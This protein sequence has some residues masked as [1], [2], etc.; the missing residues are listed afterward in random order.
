[1]DIEHIAVDSTTLF[2]SYG[3]VTAERILER[4]GVKVPHD[5]LTKAIHKQSSFYY[6]LLK[7]PLKNVM[8]GIILQQAS[9]YYV[10][11]QKLFIDYLLSPEAAKGPEAQGAQTREELEDE[12][13]KLEVM[14]EA[15][16]RVMLDHNNFISMTQNI[17]ITVTEDWKTVHE[18]LLN[19]LKSASAKLSINARTDVLELCISKICSLCD[20]KAAR[21][22]QTGELHQILTSTLENEKAEGLLSSFDG[23]LQFM[24]NF[25]ECIE[26][27]NQQADE[28]NKLACSHRT[29]FYDV[30]LRVLDLLRL[31]P[32]YK[33]DPEK[34]Q[35]NKESLYFDKTIGEHE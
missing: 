32:E 35:M 28:I 26:A 16:Q 1:M 12:R 23:M 3:V 2:S 9:D 20:L 31:L 8:N 34:D 30:I 25:E 7:I 17:L 5:L 14:N 6:Q 18:Q 11:L 21:D 19:D 10:Y 33:I 29:E 13:K 24:I 27:F 22:G 15:F 4:Y